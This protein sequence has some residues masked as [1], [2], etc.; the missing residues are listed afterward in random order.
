VNKQSSAQDNST[1]RRKTDMTL[2]YRKGAPPRPRKRGSQPRGTCAFWF[3]VGAL[4]GGFGV[5]VAWMTAEQQPTA[6]IASQPGAPEAQ[7]AQKPKF[8]FYS[9][10]PQEEVLV[11]A[12]RA[13]EPVALPPPPG[14]QPAQQP[15]PTQTAKATPPK[16]APTPSTSSGANSYLLQ[17]GSFKK[18]S[19]AERLKA[20]L[21][22]LG[23]QTSIQTVTIDS[24]ET[25][26][27]VR[28][29]SYAKADA[30]ALRARLKSNGHNAMMMKAR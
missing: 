12:E 11:P 16:P 20:Q 10:L 21:A 15:A 5:G 25:Y 23:I 29:G 17:V 4:L 1:D 28:T 7:P 6:Q 22:M 24:G 3:L 14:S 18:D 26:H 9:L 8:D 13:P 19:D 2:D 30:N 27:R